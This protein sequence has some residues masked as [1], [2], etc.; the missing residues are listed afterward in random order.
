[1]DAREFFMTVKKQRAA[2]KAF[3]ETRDRQA[4][5]DYFR[6]SD[7]IDDEIARVDKLMEDKQCEEGKKQQ[8]T[9]PTDGNT[10]S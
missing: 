10:R 3:A 9:T 1:M 8:T 2:A 6:L 4:R 7:L 5:D